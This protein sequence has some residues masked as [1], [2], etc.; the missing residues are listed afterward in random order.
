MPARNLPYP[1]GD[2]AASFLISSA[3]DMGNYLSS[4][5]NKGVFEGQRVLSESGMK[6]LHTPDEGLNYAMGWGVGKHHGTSI[7]GH[8]GS[9]PNYRTEMAI[10]PDHQRAFVLLVNAENWLSGPAVAA[11]CW[12]MKSVILGK[13]G[14]PVSKAPKLHTDLVM[15][16]VLLAGQ[17][18]VLAVGCR[19][20]YRW[21]KYPDKRKVKKRWVIFVRGGLSLAI[22]IIIAVGMFCVVPQ[23]HEITLAGLIL[24]APDAGWLLLMNGA[25]ALIAFIVSVGVM[26]FLIQ[27]SEQI[28]TA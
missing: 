6:K 14:A 2:I 23:S 12:N 27:R 26:V 4:M 5:M 21:R 13:E 19:K 17:M 3:K 8:G 18:V 15:L 16:C 24:Y 10:F 25:L 11:I 9:T 1:R 7:I 28:K 22:N 20:L